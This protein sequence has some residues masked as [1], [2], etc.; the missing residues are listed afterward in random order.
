ME[1]APRLDL[2]AGVAALTGVFCFTGAARRVLLTGV[3][4]GLSTVSWTGAA[5]RVLLAG[6]GLLTLPGD[7]AFLL[8]APPRLVLFTGEDTA[9]GIPSSV[10]GVAPFLDVFFAGVETTFT[11]VFSL[12]P[13]RRVVLFFA[14]DGAGSAA[15]CFF[16]AL[17]PFLGAFAGEA[18]SSSFA[19]SSSVC[20]GAAALRPLLAGV[21][22]GDAFF[23][24]ALLPLLGLGDG[25]FSAGVP[26]LAAGSLLGVPTFLGVTF[27]S[28]VTF[29]GDAGVAAAFFTDFGVFFGD[30]GL[31]RIGDKNNSGTPSKSS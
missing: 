4:A 2:L 28:G 12:A 21:A 25:A 8:A 23:A 26:A 15:S 7:G 22:L 10:L 18:A 13:P 31:D 29:L 17:L 14:G 3:F 19:T 20:F 9:L 24:T 6:V 30:G 1:G 5:R 11:G 16:A 27:F